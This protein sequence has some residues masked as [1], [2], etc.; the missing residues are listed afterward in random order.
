MREAKSSDR[1][2]GIKRDNQRVL[3]VC[4]SMCDEFELRRG[5][6]NLIYQ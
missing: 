4:L 2:E 6:P 1:D 3:K 5:W